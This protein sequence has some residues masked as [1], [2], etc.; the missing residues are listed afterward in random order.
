MTAVLGKPFEETIRTED[1]LP[2]ER[3]CLATGEIKPKAE[4]IRFV[5]DPE[6]RVT[7]D[8]AERLPGRGLWVSA[9]RDALQNA[10]AKNLFSKAAKTKAMASAELPD[11]VEGLL[12]RRCL[13]LLGLARAAHAVVSREPLVLEALAAGKLEAVL[14]ASDAG[15]DIR[16]KLSRAG[17]I[18]EGF[19]RQELGE[20]LG[21]EHLAA[22]GLQAHPLT[23]KLKNELKRWQKLGVSA[24]DPPEEATKAK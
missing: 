21:R 4:L 14:L 16:K 24:Y 13:E 23:T 8:L 10:V 20:A 9:S 17:E 22:L 6:G 1:L 15:A 7:P 18:F 11:L 3:R 19:T 2:S 12:K 5:L